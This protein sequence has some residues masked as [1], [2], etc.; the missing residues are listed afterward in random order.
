MTTEE[1]KWG[2]GNPKHLSP[3]TNGEPLDPERAAML[4]ALEDLDPNHIVPRPKPK[5]EPEPEQAKAKAAAA[6]EGPLPTDTGWAWW[7]GSTEE[8]Y[9]SEHETREQAIAELDG[10]DGWICEAKPGQPRLAAHLD[11]EKAVERADENFERAEDEDEEDIIFDLTEAD[12]ASLRRAIDKWQ[13]HEGLVFKSG[14]FSAQ[15]NVEFIKET[16]DE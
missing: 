8:H 3:V 15:R 9:S 6:P 5:P 2:P 10:E 12:F 4:S 14:L 1:D 7:A 13:T 11:L 16:D